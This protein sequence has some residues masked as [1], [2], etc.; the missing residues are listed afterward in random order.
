M[1]TTATGFIGVT[2]CNKLFEIEREIAL[3]SVPEKQKI[4]LEKSKPILEEFFKWVDSTLTEKY[5][6]INYLLSEISQFKNVGNEK[7]LEKLLPWSKDLPQD[8][9]NFEGEYKE[10]TIGE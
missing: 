6:Y 2:Y 4:R 10:L 1:D 9:M 7:L 8:I 3:L 5:K